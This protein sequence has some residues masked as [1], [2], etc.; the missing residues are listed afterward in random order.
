VKYLLSSGAVGGKTGK[1]AVLPG[2]CKI[3]LGCWAPP[4]SKN[5]LH[6]WRPEFKT[7]FYMLGWS[8]IELSSRGS[9]NNY[10]DNMTHCV[11]LKHYYSVEFPWWFDRKISFF[12]KTC[13]MAK[14]KATLCDLTEKLFVSNFIRWP[15]LHS[16]SQIHGWIFLKKKFLL[17][18]FLF[19]FLQDK[20]FSPWMASVGH[21][22]DKF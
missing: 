11:L 15:N 1:T 5:Y 9:F 12:S 18:Q 2:F 7:S 10:I 6:L 21:N 16:G 14:C 8:R 20:S 4:V 19:W 13:E 22:L 3:E 17:Y